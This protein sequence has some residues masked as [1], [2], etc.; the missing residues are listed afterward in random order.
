M[1]LAAGFGTRLRPLTDDCAKALVPVGDRPLLAHIVDRLHAGGV[2]RI[3]VNA[4]HRADELRAFASGCPHPVDVSEEPVLLGTAGAIE[5]AASMLGPGPVLVWNGD[6]L[7]DVNLR[8]LVLA[9]GID[10]AEATLVVRPL[11]AGKGNVGL[12][13]GG[14]IVRLR[15]VTAGAEVRGGEFVPVHVLGESLRSRL[16][17]S[18]CLIEDVYLPALR[19]GAHLRAF[20]YE[21]PWYDVGSLRSYLDANLAWLDSKGVPFWAAPHA[22]I[23][24]GVD[25]HR[26]VLGAGSSAT[27][28]SRLERC[29]VWPGAT[30][31]APL[32]DAIVTA[33]RVVQT[34]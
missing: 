15:K 25:V 3:V 7:A 18:G 2:D 22:R 17:L 6:I 20:L 26:S 24:A 30:A 1:V 4:H 10:D 32:T 31:V 23:E 13:A 9:H 34:V 5:H 28:H 8:S 21:S 12:D 19:S 16:P 27:G 11:E 33:S 29:V 14:R